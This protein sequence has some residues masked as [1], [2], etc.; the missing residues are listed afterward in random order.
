MD[1]EEVPGHYFNALALEQGVIIAFSTGQNG[2]EVEI[3]REDQPMQNFDVTLDFE[4][5]E[6]LAAFLAGV[7]PL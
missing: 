4:T 6:K 3:Q 5:V 1:I 7:K 2:V